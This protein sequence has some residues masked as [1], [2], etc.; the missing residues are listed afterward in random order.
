MLPLSSLAKQISLIKMK[1]GNLNLVIIK[2]S[3]TEM[4]FFLLQKNE[5][6]LTP[7]QGFVLR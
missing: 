1:H 5:Y 7:F 2:F 4:A 6:S 3:L